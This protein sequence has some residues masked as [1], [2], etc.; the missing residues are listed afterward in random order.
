MRVEAHDRL[1]AT[2]V[3][4]ASEVVCWDMYGQPIAV[5]QE[6]GPGSYVVSHRGDRDWQQTLASLGLMDTAILTTINAKTLTT[7]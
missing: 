4:D 7:D 2:K 1:Q 3:F 6:R 5:I